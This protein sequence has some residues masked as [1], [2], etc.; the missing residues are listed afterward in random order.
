[1]LPVAPLAFFLHLVARWLGDLHD[2][3]GDQAVCFA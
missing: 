1:M 2:G 3:G